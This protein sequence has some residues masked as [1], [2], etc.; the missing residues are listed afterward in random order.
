MP[1]CGHTKTAVRTRFQNRG[2][3]RVEGVWGRGGGGG[4]FREARARSAGA[5]VRVRQCSQEKLI[6]ANAL[7]PFSHAV[8]CLRHGRS[9]GH[10]PRRAAR[11][12]SPRASCRCAQNAAPSSPR[13]VPTPT[14]LLGALAHLAALALEAPGPLLLPLP[15]ELRPRLLV[16]VGL[17]RHRG[18]CVAQPG[19]SFFNAAAGE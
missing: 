10:E 15:P 3:V 1:S 14:P 12:P 9:V 19:H 18:R 8:P 13:R 11:T 6:C 7:R 16:R 17:V 4:C 5:R 2:C